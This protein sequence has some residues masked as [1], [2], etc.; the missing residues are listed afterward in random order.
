MSYIDWLLVFFGVPLLI[1]WVMDP[2]IFVKYRKIILRIW[3]GSIVF[4]YPWD[5][6][7]ISHKAWT[8]PKGLSGIGFL[9]LPLEEWLWGFLFSLIITYLTLY[10]LKH[11]AHDR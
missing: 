4:A 11:S 1:F 3:V 6:L 9:G 5:L 2:S 10:L 8:F 7:A